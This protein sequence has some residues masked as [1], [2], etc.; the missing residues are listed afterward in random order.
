MTKKLQL[1]NKKIQ[2]KEKL[3]TQIELL[4]VFFVDSNYRHGKRQFLTQARLDPKLYYPKK[5]VNFY[6]SEFAT[7]QVLAK[8]DCHTSLEAKIILLILFVPL[9]KLKV[10]T[11]QIKSHKSYPKKHKI[12]T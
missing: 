3:F 10:K 5:C 9:L 7:K 8:Q 4:T 1:H 12:P 6:K 11:Y 2:N